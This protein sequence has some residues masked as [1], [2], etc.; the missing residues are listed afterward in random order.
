MLQKKKNKINNN[1]SNKN[2]NNKLFNRARD[3]ALCPI[4]SA[5]FQH[6]SLS[7]EIST[8]GSQSDLRILLR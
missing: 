6:Q 8:V 1:N 4:T 3:G 2:N 7:A 5:Y